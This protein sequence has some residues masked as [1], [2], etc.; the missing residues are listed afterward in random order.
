VAAADPTFNA[1]AAAMPS[2][3]KAA[4]AA[5]AP[6]TFKPLNRNT[7]SDQSNCPFGNKKKK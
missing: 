3:P 6:A 7:T 5:T 4:T 2:A 1:A